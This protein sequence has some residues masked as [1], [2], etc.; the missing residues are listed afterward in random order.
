M[1][2][3]RRAKRLSPFE[4]LR[5]E[6][7]EFIDSLVKWV[8]WVCC[9]TSTERYR[10][11]HSQTFLLQELPSSAGVSAALRS[12]LLQ[13]L[14]G[15]EAPPQR[16]TTHFNP[17]GAQQPL[18]LPSGTSAG[19]RQ[20]WHGD[21]AKKKLGAIPKFLF[22]KAQNISSLCIPSYSRMK[23]WRLRTEPCPTRLPTSAS[24]TNSTWSAAGWLTSTTGWKWVP[25]W[26]DDAGD[27]QHLLNFPPNSCASWRVCY[28]TTIGGLIDPEE[29]MSL[30]I[31][32]QLTEVCS[33]PGL[34][35]C[36]FCCGGKPSG[37]WKL[38]ESWPSQAVSFSRPVF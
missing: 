13:F 16:N 11:S 37:F 4:V 18:L 36:C 38:R 30:M 24:H 2:E 1:N 28:P 5:N 17:V 21:L 22:L 14:F 35:Y 25:L 6:T 34:F 19:G 27:V 29:S 7:L 8:A 33:L 12:L 9:S 15:G 10:P 20:V 32:P 26:N 31:G 23:A 3:S